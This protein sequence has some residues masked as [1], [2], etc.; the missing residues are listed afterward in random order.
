VFPIS[1]L[2]LG[3]LR[4]R[5]IRRLSKP[6]KTPCFSWFY[7]FDLLAA[8]SGEKSSS[9]FHLY[10]VLEGFIHGFNLEPHVSKLFHVFEARESYSWLSFLCL[11]TFVIMAGIVTSRTVMAVFGGSWEIRAV[12]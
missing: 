1:V 12:F 5:Y 6:L 9:Q 10:P 2:G 4:G 7:W 3:H 11:G 8:K